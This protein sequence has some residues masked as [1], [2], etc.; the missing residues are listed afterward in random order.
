[1]TQELVALVMACALGFIHIVLA[2]HSASF[3]RGYRWAASARNDPRPPL[4]GLAGRFERAS[5]NYL[6]TFPFFAS[7]VLIISLTGTSTAVTVWACWIYLAAR[8]G[9]LVAYAAGIG[10][11]RV[12][13]W[14][15]AVF[16]IAAILI[17]ALLG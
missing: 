17:E 10:P 3:Q 7:G 2:S 4:T 14:N 12:V 6:E 9:F 1:M 16:S 5:R 8:L 13:F 11:V 15:V